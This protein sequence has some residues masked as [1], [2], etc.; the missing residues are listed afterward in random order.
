MKPLILLFCACCLLAV[1]SVAAQTA[2]GP[3]AAQIAILRTELRKQ[4]KAHDALRAEIASAEAQIAE[5]Q[6]KTLDQRS[7]ADSLRQEFAATNAR[8][9]VGLALLFFVLLLVA[10][11]RPRAPVSPNE[12][13]TRL[14]ALDRKLK[15]LSSP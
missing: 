1:N 2:S 8:G 4:R 5:L 15:D 14:A 3:E 6:Q 13:Q 11:R 10:F 7:D 9:A 12:L